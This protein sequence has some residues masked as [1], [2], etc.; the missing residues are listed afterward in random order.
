MG[1]VGSRWVPAASRMV[2]YGSVYQSFIDTGS[3]GD[4]S[5]TVMYWGAIDARTIT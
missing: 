2:P 3:D 1:L 4:L 5:S